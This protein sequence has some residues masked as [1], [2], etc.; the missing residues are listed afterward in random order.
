M[1]LPI[2]MMDVLRL[3]NRFVGPVKRLRE[4]LKDLAQGKQVKPLK[5]VFLTGGDAELLHPGV[6][7][8]AEHRPYLTLDGI[9][10][11][12]EALP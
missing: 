10:I 5:H 12:A 11:T 7:D 6:Q 8:T 4:G 3:S 2:V 1:L 9:R